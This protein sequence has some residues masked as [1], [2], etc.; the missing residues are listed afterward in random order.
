[1]KYI[2]AEW[3]V[4]YNFDNGVAM[5]IKVFRNREEAENFAKEHDGEAVEAKCYRS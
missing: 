2:G 3:W 1:M 4:E 5:N